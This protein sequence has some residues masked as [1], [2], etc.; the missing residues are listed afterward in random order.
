MKQELEDLMAQIKKTANQVRS[1][2]KG[3]E[4]STSLLTDQWAATYSPF[5]RLIPIIIRLHYDFDFVINSNWAKYWT[6]GAYE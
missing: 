6:R 4:P 5:V 2:L 3:K 1:K